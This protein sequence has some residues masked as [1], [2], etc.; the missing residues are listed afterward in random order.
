MNFY[1]AGLGIG[2]VGMHV[3]ALDTTDSSDD[4]SL[5]AGSRFLRNVS[6]IASERDYAPSFLSMLGFEF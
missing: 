5:W 2:L 3:M 1:E 4:E 6:R